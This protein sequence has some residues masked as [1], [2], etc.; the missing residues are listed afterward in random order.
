M[1]TT[2]LSDMLPEPS[3]WNSY[4][5]VATTQKSELFASGII[6]DMSA[7]LGNQL[8]GATVVM[9]FFKDLDS[10]DVHG[11]VQLDD[12]QDLTIDGISVDKDIAV[13]T[14]RG[15]VFGATDLSGDLASADPLTSIQNRFAAWWVR[16]YQIALLAVLKG[17]MESAGMASNRLDISALADGA[18]KFSTESFIDASFLL[19]DLSGGLTALAVHSATL[20]TMVKLDLIDTIQDSTTGL[21]IPTYMGKRVIVDDSMPVTGAGA[22]RVFTSYLFGPGAIGY[23][24]SSPKVPVETA[25]DSLKLMGQEWIVNRKQWTMHPRGIRWVGS[26]VNASGPTNTE[27]ATAANWERVYDPKLIRLVAFKHKL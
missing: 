17:S 11:E 21:S 25:R 5:E 6:A 15:K 19:G 23:A 27:L 12:T 3:E 26:A 16:R 24:S 4:I 9:P 22:D 1:A 2:K 7:E 20:K 8:E 18:A 13:K 10:S 14:L